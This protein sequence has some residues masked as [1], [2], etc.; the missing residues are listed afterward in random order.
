MMATPATRLLRYST[1]KNRFQTYVLYTMAEEVFN[2]FR[3]LSAIPPKIFSP[4]FWAVQQRRRAGEC[5][6]ANSPLTGRVL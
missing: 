5:N 1:F 4:S 2:G 3:A 6:A